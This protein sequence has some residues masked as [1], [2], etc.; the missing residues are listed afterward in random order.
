MSG[1]NG[2]NR[3]KLKISKAIEIFSGLFQKKCGQGSFADLISETV[4]DYFNGTTRPIQLKKLLTVP[5]LRLFRCVI[6]CD[7][8]M[9]EI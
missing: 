9:R 4:R 8:L 3:A 5:E 2:S 7:V 1:R 6:L